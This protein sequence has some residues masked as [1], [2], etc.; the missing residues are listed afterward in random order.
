MKERAVSNQSNMSIDD[1]IQALETN[2]HSRKGKQSEESYVASLYNKG[3]NKI[4]EKIGEEATE[5][6]LAAKDYDQ[7]IESKTNIVNEC[8]DLFFHTSVALAHLG[9]PLNE[10]FTTLQKRLGTSGHAEKASRITKE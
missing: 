1:I 2:L 10:I 7:S 6:I 5:V 9:I 4:L 8:A 3:L